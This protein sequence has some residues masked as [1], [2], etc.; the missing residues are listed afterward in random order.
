M[1]L[2]DD[3]HPADGPRSVANWQQHA[4]D[5]LDDLDL[6][7]LVAAMAGLSPEAR[8]RMATQWVRGRTR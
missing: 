1:T 7:A 3:E 4:V 2:N 5:D 8:R 6:D